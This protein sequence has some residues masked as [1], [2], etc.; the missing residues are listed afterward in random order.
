MY[1][2]YIKNNCSTRITKWVSGKGGD[3]MARKYNI[4]SKSDMR[5]LQRD[6]ERNLKKSVNSATYQHVCHACGR[7]YN[8]KVGTNRCP[9]CR[10]E[11]ILRP[12]R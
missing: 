12:A 2:I 6:L 11:F 7:R 3:L 5:R 4:A 8:V 9:N 1:T 10:A